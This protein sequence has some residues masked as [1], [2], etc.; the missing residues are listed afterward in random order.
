MKIIIRAWHQSEKERK[1]LATVG[2]KDGDAIKSS[3]WASIVLSIYATG[4]NVM[5]A[6]T[7]K[8]PEAVILGVADDLFR[9]R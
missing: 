8:D 4:L 7:S 2:L 5:L 9:Q 1:G 6:H 3:D